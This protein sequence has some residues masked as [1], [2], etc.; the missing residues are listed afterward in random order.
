M[1]ETENTAN[2]ICYEIETSEEDNHYVKFLAYV[3]DVD[4]EVVWD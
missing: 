3:V 1:N 4:E 2:V